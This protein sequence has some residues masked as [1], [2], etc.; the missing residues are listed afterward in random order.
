MTAL[1]T[2]AI[3]SLMD[4]GNEADKAKARFLEIIRNAPD[5]GTHGAVSWTRDELHER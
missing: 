2:D 4:Q 5:R 1:M 3:R